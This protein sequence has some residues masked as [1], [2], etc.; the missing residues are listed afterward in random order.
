MLG[1]DAILQL[2]PH[3]GPMCLLDSVVAWD[4][5]RVV[6]HS[7]R[8]GAPDHPL[9]VD[10]RLSSLH[11]IEY[12]A[13]AMAVHQ[14]LSG[15]GRGPVAYGLLISVRDVSLAVDRLDALA[16]PLV[17]DATR[18]AATLESLTYRFSVGT[19][20]PLVRGRASIL[21]VEGATP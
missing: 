6:C 9:R 21:L 14:R 5:D 4:D 10:G 2:I 1:R 16:S 12:A 11:A 17:I 19:D 3:K 18:I 20:V 15:R 7:E 8:Q 13:Q